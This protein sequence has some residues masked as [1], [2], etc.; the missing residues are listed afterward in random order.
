MKKRRKHRTRQQA[1]KLTEKHGFSIAGGMVC[2]NGRPCAIL[3]LDRCRVCASGRPLSCLP[4]VPCHPP[5][6]GPFPGF[7]PGRHHET[8]A[9]H[10]HF[11]SC[12]RLPPHGVGIVSATAGQFALASI[13]AM[14]WTR[15]RFGL[16]HE[17][18]RAKHRGASRR[19]ELPPA[20]KRDYNTVSPGVSRVARRGKTPPPAGRRCSRCLLPQWFPSTSP[21]G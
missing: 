13:Q 12:A 10:T 8:S 9:I 16:A 6:L 19:E 5:V 3:R 1:D 17:Q 14:A 11:L 21:I 20:G 7:F 15:V 2:C 4:R 18:N